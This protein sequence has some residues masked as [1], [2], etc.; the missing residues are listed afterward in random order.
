M[1]KVTNGV[2]S[3]M[4]PSGCFY[5]IIIQQRYLIM[6][7]SHIQDTMGV[8]S[9]LSVSVGS[10]IG[11]TFA[12]ATFLLASNFTTSNAQQQQI[13]S[14]SGGIDDGTTT[15]ITSSSSSSDTSTAAAASPFQITNDSFR[16]Q[17]PGGE[18]IPDL[19][20]AGSM[21]LEELRLQE[22]ASLP[23]APNNEQNSPVNSTDVLESNDAV[24]VISGQLAQLRTVAPDVDIENSTATEIADLLELYGLD[25]EGPVCPPCSESEE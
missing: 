19:D 3:G 21:L 11:L 13:I 20:N 15:A 18:T 22:N 5:R 4:A 6:G 17:V 2:I 12:I 9:P 8:S 25:T 23:L 1:S 7:L 10:Q 14:Q 16:V 24:D